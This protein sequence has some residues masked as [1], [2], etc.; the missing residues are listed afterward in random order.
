M[1]KNIYKRVTIILPPEV[2]ARRRKATAAAILRITQAVAAEGT[3]KNR[4]A[5][6]AALE[7][8]G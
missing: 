6:K 2:E 4:A 8:M 5:A 7:A 1:K 3:P